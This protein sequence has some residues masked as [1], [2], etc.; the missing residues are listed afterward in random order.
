MQSSILPANSAILEKTRELCADL[1]ELPEYGENKGAIER[2]LADD[3]AKA[4]YRAFADLGEELHGK[5]HAGTLTESDVERFDTEKAAL[6][7]NEVIASFMKAQDDLN[8][9]AGT[10]MK[11][12]TKTL[13]LGRV[14]TP[15]DLGGGDCCNEGGCGCH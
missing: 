15:E 2:F 3:E 11:H 4:Q 14:P 13:E 1:L 7:G 10:I 12:V 5:Q 8:E 6:G 9:M